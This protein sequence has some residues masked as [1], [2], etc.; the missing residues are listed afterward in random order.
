MELKDS[1]AL[2]TGANRGLGLAFVNALKAAGAKKIYAA[3]RD[4]SSV[5]IDGVEVIKLDV[6]SQADIAAAAKQCRDVNLVINNAGIAR[7]TSF[8]VEGTIEAARAEME[9][10]YFGPLFVARAFQPI[11]KANGGGAL[12]NVL[13]VLSWLNFPSVATY[14][15][16]K[17]AAWSLTNGLRGELREQNTL[18]VAVHVGY[19]DTDMASHVDGPKS[20]PKD[21]V[22]KVLAAVAAGDEEVLADDISNQVK[23]GLGATPGVYLQ[24]R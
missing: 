3:V 19:M 2:I 11:L 24:P 21:V 16:S 9:T 12:V 13:S 1:V 14:S 8:S 4:P 18:V 6:T 10:N 23:L 22:A 17:A 7:G 20:A 15:A 5:S